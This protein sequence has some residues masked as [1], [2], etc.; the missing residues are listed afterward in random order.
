MDILIRI[1]LMLITGFSLPYISN[2]IYSQMKDFKKL[3]IVS[4][5]GVLLFYAFIVNW[6]IILPSI[7]FI[8]CFKYV[9]VK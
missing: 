4:K 7:V 5:I 9:F 2:L 8:E 1:I 6:F 3:S